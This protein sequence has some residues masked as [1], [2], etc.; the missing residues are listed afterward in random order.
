[1]SVKMRKLGKSGPEVSAIG[2]GCMRMTPLIGKATQGPEVGID[3]IH[4]AMDAG[5]TLLNTGDFYTMGANEALVAQAIRGRRDQAFLSVKF[6]SLRGP[7]GHAIGFDARP[8]AVK[9]FCSYSLQR[10]GVDVIDLY[11]PARVDPAVPIEDTIGAV[12]DLIKEGKVRYLGVS[13]YN[14]AQLRRAH[15]VHPVTALE[16]EYSLA[17]R[18]IET[19]I[20]PTARELGIGVI[21][22]AVVTQGLLTGTLPA[23][24]PAG[25]VRR[26]FPR[27][28]GENLKT[29][30]E[31]VGV[32]RTLADSKGATPA[33]IAIAWVLAQ[34]DDIVPLVG[35]SNRSRVPENL[36][37]IDL[38]LTPEDLATLGRVFAPGAIAGTR[39]PEAALGSIAS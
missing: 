28:Q 7:S 36:G 30:M 13:E 19:E 32:L 12:A 39:Y 5:V 17:S 14:A 26:F 23:E 9:N 25:D 29:N 35:M 34:G 1:M 22:Y 20:L 33:Q 27:F 3:T 10:L 24:L 31:A 21:P 4:A 2:L 6:G 37:A 18:F 8:N 15:A 16:I 11:Q 38:V